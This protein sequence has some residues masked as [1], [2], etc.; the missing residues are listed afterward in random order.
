MPPK[1]VT[2]KKL[3]HC[4][5]CGKKTDELRNVIIKGVPYAV[6]ETCYEKLQPMEV[7]IERSWVMVYPELAFMRSPLAAMIGR[8][9]AKDALIPLGISIKREETEGARE[10]IDWNVLVGGEPIDELKKR[11]VAYVLA[12]K[13]AEDN[14]VVTARELARYLSEMA[15]HPELEPYLHKFKEENEELARSIL[16]DLADMG[17]VRKE[18]RKGERGANI[19]DYLGGERSWRKEGI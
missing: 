1:Q 17:I 9:H 8:I 16:N 12:A 13:F 18:A 2:K 6:C 19:Y 5:H 14:A 7:K 4:Q 10:E 15:N 3:E 11:G